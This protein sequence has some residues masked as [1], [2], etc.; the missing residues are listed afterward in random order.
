VKPG[1]DIIDYRRDRDLIVPGRIPLAPY[2]QVFDD[3]YGFFG[4]LSILD[5]LFNLGPEARSYMEKIT[6]VI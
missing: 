1:E 6:K 5:L 4:N 3:K 2:R